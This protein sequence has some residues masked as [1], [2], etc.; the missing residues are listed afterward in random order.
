MEKLPQ[1]EKHHE[2]AEVSAAP[3]ARRNDPLPQ[4]ELASIKLDELHLPARK[5]RKCTPAHVREVM[6]SISALGCVI[7]SLSAR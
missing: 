4:I 7:P 6:N 5:T 3:R 2:L 1:A